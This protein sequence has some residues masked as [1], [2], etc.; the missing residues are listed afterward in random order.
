[1]ARAL[2]DSD[3]PTIFNTG[4]VL[5]GWVRAYEVEGDERYLKSA[6]RAADWLSDTQDEDGCWRRY[7]SPMTSRHVN[8]Y[9]TRTA[10]ALARAYQMSDEQRYLDCAI[11]NCDWA[12]TQ[13]ND[14]GWL[15]QNCLLDD[16]QPYVHTIAYAMRGLLEVGQR[17]H[18]PRW[19]K[20]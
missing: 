4:Q 2:G 13:R 12:M 16:T 15:A 11:R 17:A 3:Q 18:G 5:F 7:D 14:K 20:S 9:N 1:M 19:F 6:I 10:L 8:T